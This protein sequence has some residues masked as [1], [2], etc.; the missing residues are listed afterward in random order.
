MATGNSSENASIAQR[1][2]RTAAKA[3]GVRINAA[4]GAAVAGVIVF[5]P[6]QASASQASLAALAT[7]GA[8][9]TPVQAAASFYIQQSDRIGG[10]VGHIDVPTM[11]M[12][13]SSLSQALD[14][15]LSDRGI[16]VVVR[17]PLAQDA[18]QKTARGV[19]GSLEQ[20]LNQLSQSL[21]FFWVAAD[22]VVTIDGT[23]SFSLVIPAAF[24][25]D[26][27]AVEKT[28]S[29]AGAT[30]VTPV[31]LDNIVTFRASPS[32]LLGI[33]QTLN[34]SAARRSLAPVAIAFGPRPHVEAQAK[35]AEQAQALAQSYAPKTMQD[36]SGAMAPVPAAHVAV[37]PMPMIAAPIVSPSLPQAA[38][39]VPTTQIAT[40][41]AAAPAA[42]RQP[43][44]SQ[45]PA[46]AGAMTPT[47]R[48]E[49]MAAAGAQAAPKFW[50]I[51]V[52]D[53][54]VEGV[55]RRWARE[56]GWELRY[57][58]DRIP[59]LRPASVIAADFLGAV[60]EVQ[61]QLVE[62]GYDMDLA[63]I[64]STLRVSPGGNK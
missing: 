14:L 57:E 9:L 31:P 11:S 58:F 38:P 54:T 24:A 33:Q 28:L 21:N 4:I 62:A 23:R 36:Q 63:A 10:D 16:T 13:G 46:M 19:K 15:A 55:L 41:A 44:V 5:A 51:N 37:A 12:T 61:L 45:A 56:S 1:I 20:V 2:V 3:W 43:I 39:V 49:S 52:A 32:V 30:D 7:V 25:A 29:A 34:A 40:V 27:S 26:R 35:V 60:K 64:G 47:P 42:Q 53:R 50:G 22:G 6:T 48:V 18:A 8:T 17:S 59:V